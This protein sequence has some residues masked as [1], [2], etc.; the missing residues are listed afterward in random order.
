MITLCVDHLLKSVTLRPL[1]R[2]F[3]TFYGFLSSVSYHGFFL[4]GDGL[5]W[6]ALKFQKR[7]LN[8]FL[9][10]VQVEVN[11]SERGMP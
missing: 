2:V 11:F 1:Q 10:K 3:L 4:Q 6:I 9:S 7:I 8:T 5:R